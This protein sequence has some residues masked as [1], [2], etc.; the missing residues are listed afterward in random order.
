MYNKYEWTSTKGTEPETNDR[1]IQKQTQIRPK[2]E[3]LFTP[4]AIQYCYLLF[5][6]RLSI[7]AG[8]S[9]INIGYEA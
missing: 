6:R 1:K 9:T 8:I 7:P 3:N 5:R 4:Q 2:N